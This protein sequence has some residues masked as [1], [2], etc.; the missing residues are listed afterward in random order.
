MAHLLTVSGEGFLSAIFSFMQGVEAEA[1]SLSEPRFVTG[2][3]C[4]RESW[5][6]VSLRRRLA[7]E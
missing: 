6:V 1:Q 7:A 2:L 3:R 5:F 4:H